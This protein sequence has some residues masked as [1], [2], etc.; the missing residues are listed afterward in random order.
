MRV[1]EWV[2]QARE[3]RITLLPPPP[4]PTEL[5]PAGNPAAV[6]ARRLRRRQEH[7]EQRL[8]ARRWLVRH[9]L[10]GCA[11]LASLVAFAWVFVGL[12]K[13]SHCREV[14]RLLAQVTAEERTY[15][16]M[17]VVQPLDGMSAAGYRAFHLQV[18][19]INQSRERYNA[20][21][22]H[23]ARI[24]EVPRMDWLCRLFGV[25]RGYPRLAPMT[26]PHMSPA[27]PE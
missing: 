23:Y 27:K 20:A 24:G 15:E 10:W 13:R 4:V 11:F 21:A 3:D 16:Q 9:F 17:Q 18:L 19:R 14:E 8:D 2:P 22:A 7:L 5:H 12:T 25:P 1:S 6:E 26:D